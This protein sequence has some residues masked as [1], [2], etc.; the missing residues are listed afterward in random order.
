MAQAV[1]VPGKSLF[2]KVGDGGSPETFTHNCS[3]NAQRGLQ[4]S[5]QT[6]DVNVPD[7]DDPDLM[8]WVEREKVSLSGAI[9]GSGVLNAPDQDL[10][11]E[12]FSSADPKNVKVITDIAG[13]SGGRV[14]TGAWLCTG[15]DITGNRGEKCQCA[16]TLASNGAITFANNT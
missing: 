14:F 5:A 3:I 8:A 13:A 12:W 9:N 4:L 7:C 6:N 15:F 10:F 16:I 1:T 11:W 2:I